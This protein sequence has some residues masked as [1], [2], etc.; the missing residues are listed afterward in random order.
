[1]RNALAN[2]GKLSLVAV[3]VLAI[4]SLLGAHVIMETL[5]VGHPTGQ[6]V[7]TYAK[8]VDNK[9][10]FYAALE[11]SDG[12]REVFENRDAL[13]SWKFNSADVN[14]E[15]VKA[16]QKGERVRVRVTGVRLPISSWFRNITSLE[17]G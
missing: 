1:M 6:V 15:L 3:G 8:R 14:Q 7:D 17:N 13:W 12:T 10:R 5:V 11:Y 4:V 16:K 2:L 9:D